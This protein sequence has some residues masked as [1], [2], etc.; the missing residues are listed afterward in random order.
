MGACVGDW[1]REEQRLPRAN[2]VPDTMPGALLKFSF[3]TPQQP[4]EWNIF[5]SL[6]QTRKLRPGEGESFESGHTACEKM[7]QN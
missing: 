4:F 5:I 7:S 6:L 3:K 1:D 2:S